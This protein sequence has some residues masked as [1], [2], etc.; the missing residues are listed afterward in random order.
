MPRPKSVTVTSSNTPYYIPMNWRG[1]DISIIADATGTV[2]YD[3]AFTNADIGDGAANVSATAWVD[4]TNM[5]A[6]TADQDEVI[7]GCTCL[8]VTHNSGA[9]SVTL[10][11]SQEDS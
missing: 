4:V 1:G 6:A 11:I 9:G 8:R 3:V 7:V 5:S 2:N 10:Y